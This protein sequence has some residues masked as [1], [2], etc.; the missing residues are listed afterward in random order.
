MKASKMVLYAGQHD[1]EP[2]LPG[3]L[4]PKPGMPQSKTVAVLAQ[5]LQNSGVKGYGRAWTVQNLSKYSVNVI[6]SWHQRLY[7]SRTTEFWGLRSVYC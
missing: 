4:P 1:W 6:H 7:G 2:W 5:R 3:R